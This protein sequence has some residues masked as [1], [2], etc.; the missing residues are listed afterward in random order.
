MKFSHPAHS[1]QGFFFAADT[2]EL[3]DHKLTKDMAD[4]IKL[5]ENIKISE[6]L[7]KHGYFH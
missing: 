7:T 3:S 5:E 2:Y 6:K 1:R 4:I